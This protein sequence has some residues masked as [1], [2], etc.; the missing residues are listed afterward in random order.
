MIVREAIDFKRGQTSKKAL[1]VGRFH[2]DPN[3]KWFHEQALERGYKETTP[4]NYP[5]GPDSDEL[6]HLGTY[7]KGNIRLDVVTSTDR[8]YL[9]IGSDDYDAFY[10]ESY[11]GN[12]HVYEP[13]GEWVGND[14]WWDQVETLAK[15]A[16]NEN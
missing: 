6:I 1:D 4:K 9:N 16:F 13:F 5:T 8:E 14:Y 12:E 10:I 11:I 2:D 15:E 3:R 7:D